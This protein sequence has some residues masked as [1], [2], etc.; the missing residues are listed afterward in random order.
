VQQQNLQIAVKKGD[1]VTFSYDNYSRHAVPVNA[2]INRIRCDVSWEE[3]VENYERDQQFQ[4][5]EGTVI[6]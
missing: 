6:K 1:V 4:M 5:S 2:K 3:I